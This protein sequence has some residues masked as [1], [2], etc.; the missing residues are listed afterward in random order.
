MSDQ[1]FG[2][3]PPVNTTSNTDAGQ[4]AALV[5]QLVKERLAA[6][7]LQNI[8]PPKVVSPEE[9]A[10]NAIDNHGVGLGIDERLNELYRHLDTIAKKVGI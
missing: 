8:E 5:E 1:D 7:G 4:L 10:R 2:Y 3:T 9:A 6:A